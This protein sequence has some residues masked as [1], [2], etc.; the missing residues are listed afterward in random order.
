MCLWSFHVKH[1]VKKQV[2]FG[3]ILLAV[4]KEGNPLDICQMSEM[5]KI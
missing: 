3:E 4:L 5:Q 1:S 2:V